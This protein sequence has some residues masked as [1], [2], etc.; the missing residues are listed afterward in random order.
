M[1]NK[2][3]IKKVNK[4]KIQLIKNH[5]YNPQINM[6]SSIKDSYQLNK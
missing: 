1:V 6:T 3:L 2:S 5:N 4:T